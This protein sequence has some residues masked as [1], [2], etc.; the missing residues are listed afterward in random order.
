MKNSQQNPASAMPEIGK[1]NITES[2]VFI[3]RIAYKRQQPVN[4]VDMA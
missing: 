3:I 2:S 4:L 1:L